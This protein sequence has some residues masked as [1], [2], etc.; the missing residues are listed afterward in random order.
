MIQDIYN[1][2][3]SNTHYSIIITNTLWLVTVT[4]SA[5]NTHR[6][7]DR[8]RVAIKFNIKNY[9]NLLIIQWCNNYYNYS[10]LQ[11]L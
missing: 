9:N 8:E 7:T 4:Q 5:I 3:V 10:Y 11:L 1:H 2:S 6:Q